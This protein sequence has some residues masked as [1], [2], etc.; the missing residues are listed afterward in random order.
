[1][2]ELTLGCRQYSDRVA[3]RGYALS[4]TTV[5]KILVDHCLGRAAS[6][7]REQRR[8]LRRPRG[9][10]SSRSLMSRSGSPLRR[11]PHD[12]RH[13]AASVLIDRGRR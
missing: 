3:D 11:S 13:Y 12:L 6:G 9:S 10:S 8:S 4:K 7:S 2:V 1:V 5:Q